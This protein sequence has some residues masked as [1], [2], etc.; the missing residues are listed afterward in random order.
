MSLTRQQIAEK[1]RNAR[2]STGMSQTE[3]AKK[4][5]V[6][7]VALN[8]I[9][10]GKRRVDSLEMA[11]L[12]AA[13]RVPLSE[14]LGQG[15]EMEPLQVLFRAADAALSRGGVKDSVL[16][17]FGLFREISILRGQ[18]LGGR[19]RSLAPF[20]Y[21]W[22]APGSKEEACDHGEKVAQQ[23]RGRLNLGI[24]ALGG[25]A[26][27][28]AQQGVEVSELK[29]PADISGFTVFQGLDALMVVNAA[30]HPVRR[31]FSL[32][33][34]YG[35]VLMDGRRQAVVSRERE[36]GDLLETRA[37]AFAA[38]FLM[39]PEGV[40]Q[41]IQR[42]GIASFGWLETANLAWYFGVGYKVAVYRLCNLG[43][44]NKASRDQILGKEAG[45]RDF[46]THLRREAPPVDPGAKNLAGQ[47]IQWSLKA[48]VDGKI[49]RRKA[50]ELARKAGWREGTF[51][52]Y[53]G[54]MGWSRPAAGLVGPR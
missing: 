31:V 42:Q 53:A 32:A 1:L 16:D 52:K 37:N 10:A 7:R 46:F 20:S 33:H 12:A 14:L 45:A 47:L 22:E 50:L 11:R 34:E 49:S 6:G 48:L 28:V 13:Y 38:A 2:E 43:Y 27:V 18:V 30:H 25:I 24:Q 29:L 40:S 26:G 35:H 51:E 23:E 19:R 9:E 36:K 44:L 3:A 4:A 17:A 54:D 8:Q 5:D 39:P 21:P 41:F 15:G